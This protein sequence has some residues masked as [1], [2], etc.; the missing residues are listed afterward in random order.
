MAD[1]PVGASAWR[2]GAHRSAGGVVSAR[3]GQ[4]AGTAARA[5]RAGRWC[6]PA[7]PLVDAPA[8]AQ[9]AS[10]AAARIAPAAEADRRRAFTPQLRPRASPIT[11]LPGGLSSEGSY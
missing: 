8:A 7:T 3:G 2:A 1:A 5:P 9:Q 10:A 4:A 6:D 11:P